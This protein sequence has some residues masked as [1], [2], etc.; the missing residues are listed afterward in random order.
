MEVKKS[1]QILKI[2]SKG[3]YRKR[4]EKLP[5]VHTSIGGGII[6]NYPK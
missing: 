5:E 2:K 3:G 1:P 6:K 4:P